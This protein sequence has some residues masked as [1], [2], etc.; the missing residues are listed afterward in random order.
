MIKY[1]AECI[2]TFFLVFCGTGA[3]IIN[4]ETNG[5]ITHSGIAITF[6]LIVMTM[7]YSLGSISGAHLN[8]AVSIALT[9]AG[10]FDIKQI[11]PYILSQL[12]GAFFASI[13]LTLLFPSNN[14]LGSTLPQG[15]AVQSFILELILT[16]CLMFVILN[17][18]FGS[19]DTAPLAGFIIGSTVLL[20]AMFAGPICGASM[21]PARSISPAC[22]SGHLEHLWIYILAPIFGA[23]LAVPMWK[24]LNHKITSL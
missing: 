16:C 1:V 22:V 12:T 10:K 6:G 5:V 9:L 15:S 7:I 18:A 4:E 21:N 19:K 23:L 2:G 3:I 20:E 17:T 13:I 8:P 14:L 11:A 24:I